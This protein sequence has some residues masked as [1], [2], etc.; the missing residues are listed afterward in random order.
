MTSTPD[1]ITS[2]KIAPGAVIVHN[3]MFD[4]SSFDGHHKNGNSSIQRWNWNPRPLEH[5]STPIA[6]RPGLLPLKTAI[7]T[8]RMMRQWIN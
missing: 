3:I 5:E 8:S 2:N 1:D 4:V 6:T 7:L